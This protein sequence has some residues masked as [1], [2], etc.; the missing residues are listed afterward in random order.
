MSY[1]LTLALPNLDM[2]PK[3]ATKSLHLIHLDMKQLLLLPL[4]KFYIERQ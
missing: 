4:N 1:C 3:F 2:F